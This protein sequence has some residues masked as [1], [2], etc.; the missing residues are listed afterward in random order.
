M[1]H[2]LIILYGNFMI[3]LYVIGFRHSMELY[4]ITVPGV[5]IAMERAGCEWPRG[6]HEVQAVQTARKEY[7]WRGLDAEQK[8]AFAVAARDGWQVWEDNDAVEVLSEQEAKDVRE[9]LKASNEMHKILTPRFVFTD[10]HDGLRTQSRPLPL[11]ANA[12]LLVP[13]FRDP[14]AYAVR[15]DAPT[16]SRISQHLLLAFI[17]SFGWE[18]W[19][20]DVK[21]AFLKGELFGPHERELYIGWIRTVM[22]DEPQLP[23]GQG[24]L[25]RLKKGIFGL[26]DSARR[27]FAC[28]R[29]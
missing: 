6:D 26:S 15:K 8:R 14:T 21:S 11:K 4:S 18:L 12:R 24:G 13:E 5:E 27:W 29:R 2:L 1:F 10:K 23:L 3:K 28:T 17:A 25:A 20:A 22:G 16:A 7:K 9:R 19:S